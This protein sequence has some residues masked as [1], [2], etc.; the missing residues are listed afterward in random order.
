MVTLTGH[1]GLISVTHTGEKKLRENTWSRVTP[2]V[3]KE[4]IAEHNTS[5]ILP[6]HIYTN[7]KLTD[8]FI[9]LPVENPWVRNQHWSEPYLFHGGVSILMQL[10]EIGVSYTLSN[11]SR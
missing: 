3:A 11:L 4:T 2:G 1:G 6:H 9:R 10:R 5:V 8:L 7:F